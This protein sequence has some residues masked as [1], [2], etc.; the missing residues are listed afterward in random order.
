MRRTITILL[1]LFGLN[2]ILSGIKHIPIPCFEALS[3]HFDLGHAICG[4]IF[5]I[6]IAIHVWL[7]RKPLF[8]YF[9]NLGWWWLPV[10][11]GFVAVIWGGVV[12]TVLAAL[13]I[14]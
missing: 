14:F 1:V 10:G 8:R 7:N 2:E 12:I 6:L 4:G 3:E 5:M 9:S 13:G 11:L